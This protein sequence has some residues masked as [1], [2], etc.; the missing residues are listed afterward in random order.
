MKCS[1]IIV[2]Y[3]AKDYTNICL[4]KLLRESLPDLYELILLDNKSTDGVIDIIKYYENQKNIKIIYSTEN[5]GFAKGNNKAVQQ[6]TGEYVF[7]LNPDTEIE[8]S[9]IKKLV[10]YLDNNKS[11]GV[12]GPKI[13]DAGGLVQE[14]YGKEMTFWTEFLGKIF[15]SV[16]IQNFPFVRNIRMNYYDKKNITNVGWIGG[17]GILIRKEL[18]DKIGGIDTNFFYCAG[19]MVDLC[20]QIKELGYRVVFYPDAKM[21]HKGGVSTNGDKVNALKKSYDGTL[22]YF[23]KHKKPI[24]RFFVRLIYIVISFL[25]SIIAFFL[26]LIIQKKSFIDIAKSHFLNSGFLFIGLFS[27]NKKQ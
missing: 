27:L 7:L 16:Y 11:V 19:D 13:Y 20:S 9:E 3:N 24:S 4:K 2:T 22:Y 12:V 21:I 26:G 6:A 15:G 17:A 10:L 25:K 5:L 1:I 14:S 18:Y 23:A 8:I